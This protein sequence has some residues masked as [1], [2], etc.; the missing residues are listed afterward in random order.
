MREIVRSKM[1]GRILSSSL[2]AYDELSMGTIDQ[3]NVYLLDPE[4]GANPLT[5][6]TGHYLD[7][8]CYALGEVKAASAAITVSRPEIKIRQSGKNVISNSP[9][10]IAIAGILVDDSVLSFHMRAGTGDPSFIWEIQGDERILRVTS[11]GY[12]MWRPLKLE[13]GDLSS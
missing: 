2:I 9:D 12:L 4:N 1:L 6:H 8:V 11:T 5:L 10:Q 3:G 13:L 7:A